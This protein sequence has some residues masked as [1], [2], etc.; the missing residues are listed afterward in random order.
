MKKI[1][2]FINER[3]YLFSIFCVLLI[4]LLAFIDIVREYSQG[5]SK[6]H[7]IFE[8]VVAILAAAWGF[9]LLGKW[10][11]VKEDLQRAQKV[12]VQHSEENKKWREEYK[13]LLQGL[14]QSI[15]EQFENWKLSPSEK[16]IALLLLKGLSLKEISEI[17]KTSEKTTRLQA[18]G[19]Y[20][21]SGLPGRA[22]L[23]AFFLEDFLSTSQ[24]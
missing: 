3:S 9:Y 6:G 22:E 10:H 18:S 5:E 21:K 2:F 11:K 12:I 14:G 4:A 8:V 19:I 23:S 7:L 16:D 24:S 1:R 17:R 13:K 15:D 20:A